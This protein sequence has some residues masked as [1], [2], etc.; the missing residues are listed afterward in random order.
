MGGGY[1]YNSSF[2][3]TLQEALEREG[4]A[5]IE[6]IAEETARNNAYKSIFSDFKNE[7]SSDI[8]VTGS[9]DN[10]ENSYSKIQEWCSKLLNT[11]YSYSAWRKNK[12]N[13]VKYC[14]DRK[15]IKVESWLRRLGHNNWAND[16]EYKAIFAVY[17]FSSKF[18][19]VINKAKN[20]GEKDYIASEKIATGYLRLKKWCTQNLGLFT[21][22]VQDLILYSQ[23]TWWCKPLGYDDVKG[24]IKK[25]YGESWKKEESNETE[26]GKPWDEIKDFWNKDFDVK[27]YIKLGS[28]AAT[29]LSA[30]EYKKW[31]SEILDKKLSEEGIY[32]KNYKAA[33][34]VCVEL[35]VQKKLKET[36]N[37]RKAIE[38]ANKT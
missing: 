23:L 31:C 21:A 16:E 37:L 38:E 24:R 13:L 22:D 35:K 27:S 7:I 5:F 3:R 12:P 28:N 26:A 9:T 10:F 17:R 20:V 29:V 14:S 30:Y 18:R 11:A 25:M 1:A 36:K 6:S 33:K 34:S 15:P 32:V 19:D 8:S 4:I 2:P